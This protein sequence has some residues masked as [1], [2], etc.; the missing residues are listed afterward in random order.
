VPLHAQP[1]LRRIGRAIHAT[2][3]EIAVNVRSRS[4]IMRVA[5]KVAA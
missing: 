2:P 3:A 1:K 4:A 5:E